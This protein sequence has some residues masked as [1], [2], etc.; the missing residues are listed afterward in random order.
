MSLDEICIGLARLHGMGIRVLYIEGGEP[1]LWHEN[2][3]DLEDVVV[4]A[5]DTGFHSV[6]VYTNGTFPIHT[7]ANA[8]FVSLD[9]TR[10]C[11]DLLR[12]R[13]FDTIIAN[14]NAST[15]PNILIN[16]TIN[17][18]NESEIPQF[19]GEIC[20]NSHIRGI[21]F[22]FYT[23]YAG[24]D[25]LSLDNEEKRRIINRLLTLK[26]GG[27]PIRNSRAALERVLDG[28]WRRPSDLCYLYADRMMYRCCRAV[29]NADICEECGYLGCAEIDCI[30]RLQPG[31][32]MEVIRAL[33]RRRA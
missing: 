28:S 7:G 24:P 5:R 33:S 26:A 20:R 30:A 31:A 3:R 6:I 21:F 8:V 19:C 27:L 14:I 1:F 16:F 2:G 22:Y 32:I 4:A 15:H 12:G 17:R 10:D 11:N 13:S 9:G 29:G 18:I 25:D 23:P